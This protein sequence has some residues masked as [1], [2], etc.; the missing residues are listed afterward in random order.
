MKKILSILICLC[1]V[2]SLL[3]VGAL[4][5]HTCVD[6]DNDYWCDRCHEWI[7]HEC[8]DDDGDY[9]CDAC[10]LPAGHDCLSVQRLHR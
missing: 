5:E 2:C 3:P 6:R 8:A 4:A 9:W 10:W 1:M 7:P